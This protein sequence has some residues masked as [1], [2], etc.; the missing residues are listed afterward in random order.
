MWQGLRSDFAKYNKDRFYEISDAVDAGDLKLAQRLAH[1]LKSNA[2]MLGKEK[3]Q[4]AAEDVERRLEKGEDLAGSKQMAVLEAELDE[5]L[6]ELLPLVAETSWP[7]REAA[8]EGFDTMGDEEE[9]GQPKRNSLLIIDDDLMSL[10]QLILI[11]QP[12]YKVYTAKDGKSG[13]RKM[14]KSMP[15]IVLLDVVMPD[16]SGFEVLA[17]MQKSDIM[18]EIPVIMITGLSVGEY[19]ERAPIAGAAG[20]IHKPYDVDDI[21][22]SVRRQMEIV[23]RRKDA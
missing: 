13:L 2:G 8:A 16:M 22:G 17:E 18:R 20:F 5:V 9:P 14:E 6:A 10:K 11:L 23:N 3:L 12:E 1:N 19:E 15:D 7:A 4:L 21:K